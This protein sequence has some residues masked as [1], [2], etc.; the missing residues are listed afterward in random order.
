MAREL[1]PGRHLS[2][3]SGPGIN[4]RDFVEFNE[5]ITPEVTEVLTAANVWSP[6]K[7]PDRRC[8][9]EAPSK[10]PDRRCAEEA[11][12]PKEASIWSPPKE[13]AEETEPLSGAPELDGSHAG[14]GEPPTPPA[15]PAHPR[16]A[17]GRAARGS[18]ATAVL[19]GFVVAAV[20][21]AHTVGGM[22]LLARDSS[23]EARAARIVEDRDGGLQAEPARASAGPAR[24]ALRGLVGDL[25]DVAAVASVG[26]VTN[27]TMVIISSDHHG[28]HGHH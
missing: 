7:R 28:H 9:E 22:A 5:D 12:P 20:A 15:V 27:T 16:L 23:A 1:Q 21:V 18:V 19:L 25:G 10:R 4:W 24:G 3:D 11:E 13:A 14:E 6:S 8:S 17:G 26:K 2:Q